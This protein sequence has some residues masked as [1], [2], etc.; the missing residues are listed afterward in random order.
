MRLLVLLLLLL[1]FRLFAADDYLL[2]LQGKVE[3]AT[4]FSQ[5]LSAYE[6]WLEAAILVHHPDA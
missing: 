2:M 1:P 6:N 3:K 5:K 4:T